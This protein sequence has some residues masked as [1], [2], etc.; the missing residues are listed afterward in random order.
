[1]WVGASVPTCG[2]QR[3]S[4]GWLLGAPASSPAL[5]R[6]DRSIDSKSFACED[7]GAPRGRPA[8]IGNGRTA[9]EARTHMNLDVGRSAR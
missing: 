6:N 3:L 8:N 9:A 1:M 2:L 4:H 5:F 7:A